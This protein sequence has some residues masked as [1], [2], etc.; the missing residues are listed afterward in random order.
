M[1]EWSD[2]GNSITILTQINT[3]IGMVCVF[4][5]QLHQASNV[6]EEDPAMPEREPRTSS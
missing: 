1:S 3:H 2:Y 6:L 5:G 4:F